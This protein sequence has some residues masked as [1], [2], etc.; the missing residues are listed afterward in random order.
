[1][2]RYIAAEH[3]GCCM[4]LSGAGTAEEMAAQAV[5]IFKNFSLSKEAVWLS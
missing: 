5:R 4:M 2:V 3:I 1:M